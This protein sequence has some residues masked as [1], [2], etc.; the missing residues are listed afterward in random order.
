MPLQSVLA[1][2]PGVAGYEAG[3][4]ANNVNALSRIR[5]A[6][7]AM[8]VQEA[9][10]KRQQRENV[11]NALRGAGS[12]YDAAA[13]GV[14]SAGDI[15]GADHLR[16]MAN[17][18][19]I[20][21]GV[22]AL[23][24]N[25]PDIA[26]KLSVLAMKR[27][28]LASGISTLERAREAKVKQADTEAGR[29]SVLD[30]AGTPEV[31]PTFEK[32]DEGNPLPVIP[33]KPSAISG[34][35]NHSNPAIKAGAQALQ[36]LMQTGRIGPKEFQDGLGKLEQLAAAHEQGQANRQTKVD[37]ASMVQEGLD[38]R[39]AEKIAK[40][41]SEPATL[42]AAKGFI[43]LKMTTTNPETGKP[44]TKEEATSEVLAKQIGVQKG[45]IT[46]AVILQYEG[47]VRR[48][49]E[50]P[51]TVPA[52]VAAGLDRARALAKPRGPVKPQPTAADIAYAK[53]HPEV[54]DKFKARFG[55]DVPK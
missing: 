24:P 40:G 53:A 20:S 15:T 21:K 39:S 19:A 44:Y 50:D 12:D 1:S 34:Y 25:D 52:E 28:N 54:A 5:T 47:A 35:L 13:R 55:T 41:I 43:D 4:E 10:A 16:R 46:P 23:D 18:D 3:Q 38:R 26:T 9:M 51:K 32:D 37:V 48:S 33:G 6:E 45:E 49:A 7:G 42:R 36:G 22:S 30:L 31:R 14:L 11:L 2:I 17:E 27:G 8:G 29:K